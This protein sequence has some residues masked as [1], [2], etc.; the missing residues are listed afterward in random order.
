MQPMFSVVKALI[1]SRVEWGLC[2][3]TFMCCCIKEAER[4][5]EDSQQ[6]GGDQE[7]SEQGGQSSKWVN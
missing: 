1:L 2:E 6:A 7:D 5:Q 3:F 4:G